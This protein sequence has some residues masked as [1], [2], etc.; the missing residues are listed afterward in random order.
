MVLVEQAL[1]VRSDVAAEETRSAFPFSRAIWLMAR[2]TGDV[3]TSTITSTFS[4]SYH[5]F[6]IRAP[7]STL[8]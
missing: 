7:T 1:P 8:F 6:A 3:G 4:A 5:C 2:A